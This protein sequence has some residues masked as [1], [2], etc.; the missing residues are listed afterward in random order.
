MKRY[1]GQCHCGKVHYQAN[2][3]LSTPVRYVDGLQE[4]WLEPPAVVS[5]L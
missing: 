5:H 2:I 1:H 4:R 3:D